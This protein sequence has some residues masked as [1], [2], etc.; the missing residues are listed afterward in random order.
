MSGGPIVRV[1]GRIAGMLNA[2]KD[3]LWERI[4]KVNNQAYAKAAAAEQAGEQSGGGGG[5]GG[6]MMHG[7]IDLSCEPRPLTLR[8][9]DAVSD[10]HVVALHHDVLPRRD[11]EEE[12]SRPHSRVRRRSTPREEEEEQEITEH[13]LDGVKLV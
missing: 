2:T 3:V 5:G 1:E 8:A 9:Q 10:D 7:A 12:G 4:A 6:V 11:R 13:G